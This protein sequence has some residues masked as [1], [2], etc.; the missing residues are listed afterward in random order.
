[1]FDTPTLA[2]VS[3]IIPVRDG[4]DAFQN[5]LQHILALKPA[6]RQLIVVDDGSVD[7]SPEWAK[8]AGAMVISSPTPR[9]PAH[10]RNVGATYA[11]SKL[12]FFVDADV[13]VPPDTL[14]RIRTAF[15]ANASL[16]ALIGSYDD[17]PSAPNFLS[18]YRNLLHHFVHQTGREEASTFWGGCGVIRRSVFMEMGGFDA[19][20]ER[21][22]IEDIE[23]GYRLRE[24]GHRIRLLKSLQVKHLK[25]WTAGTLIQTDFYQRA[26]PWSRLL[27]ERERLDNDLNLQ[28][29]SRMSVVLALWLVGA[30]ASATLVARWRAVSGVV[31][32]AAAAG[33]L[34]L[35]HP[36]YRFF[37]RTRG[38]LFTLR[39]IPWHWLYY[40]YSGLAFGI[41]YI[42]GCVPHSRGHS[43]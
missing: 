29:S 31:S 25:R 43:G 6:P 1:M 38:L 34:A 35:N 20:Y 19:S 5:C 33:L 40:L 22:S 10:A 11:G 15:E 23:L 3:I 4:G 30:L 41:A 9:G 18:Q 42:E 14:A 12:L 27:L 24:A 13:A 17:A 37:L 8:A 7:N 36:L 21:P 32:A 28:I 26:L 39:V 16:S 2:D